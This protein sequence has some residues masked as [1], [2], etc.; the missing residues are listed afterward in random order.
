MIKISSLIKKYGDFKALNNV[1][2]E[3]S[4]GSV[5]GLVGINGAGKSTLLRTI[6]GIYKPDAG[7]VRYDGKSVYDNPRV[8]REIAFVPDELYL[9]DHATVD[10]MSQ[11][12]KDLYGGKFSSAK[13]REL[14]ATF[15]LDPSAR[16]NS[17]SKGMRRQASTILA[18][19]LETKYIFFDET[20]DGL[21]PLKRAFVKKMIVEDVKSRGATAIISSHSLRELSDICDKIAV[22][23]KGRLI[24][25]SSISDYCGDVIKVQAAFKNGAD[26]SPLNSMNII[27]S[28]KSGSVYTLVIRGEKN[29]ALATLRAMSPIL[30]E[31]LPLSIEEVFNV[32]LARNGVDAFSLLLGEGHDNV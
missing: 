28:A 27:E 10:F 15:K 31:T 1:N 32:E 29:K 16:F 21:D 18:L 13:Y 23:N 19:S 12:F 14:L 2:L 20:F 8:K 22:L 30:L 7:N 24:L 17:F 3:I 9:P 6:A 4:N 26:L 5:Y 11:K 25:E